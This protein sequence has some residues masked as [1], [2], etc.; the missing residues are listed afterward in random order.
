MQNAAYFKVGDRVE[1]V[2]MDDPYVDAPSGV[3]GTVL[4]VAP[5]PINVL[6]VAW[7]NG[8]SLNPCLDVDV[9]RMVSK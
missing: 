1:L 5:P 3:H 7:D 8:F 4:G 2:F 6:D 9:V